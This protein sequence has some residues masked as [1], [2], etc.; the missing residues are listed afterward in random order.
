MVT[1]KG[2]YWLLFIKWNKVYWFSFDTFNNK[3]ILNVLLS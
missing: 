1:I 3:K 2:V